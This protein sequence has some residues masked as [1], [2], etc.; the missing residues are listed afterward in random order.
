MSEESLMQKRR[1]TKSLSR[2]DVLP[3]SV[4]EQ[5][6]PHLK[7][8]RGLAPCA[9][10][11]GVDLGRAKSWTQLLLSW[12]QASSSAS[13]PAPH[14]LNS[15]CQISLPRLRNASIRV[16]CTSCLHIF[17]PLCPQTLCSLF[18]SLHEPA[19]P[20]HVHS[21]GV[22]EAPVVHQVLCQAMRK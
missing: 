21:A 18:P 16:F 5:L 4:S 8:T 3:P 11:C 12:H 6:S 19:W 1:R 9:T 15:T 22:Y 20:R 17:L 2:V 7:A 10:L 14:S 13:E